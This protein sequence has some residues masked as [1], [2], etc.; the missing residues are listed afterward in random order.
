MQYNKGM[1]SNSR[2]E[3]ENRLH[4]RSSVEALTGL[5]N[6]Y[7]SVNLSQLSDD[8]KK[9]LTRLL[10]AEINKIKGNLPQY[11]KSH[12]GLWISSREEWLNRG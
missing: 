9:E 4:A 6:R 11:Y 3:Y 1:L 7:H 12:I 5:L 2:Q 8:Q 10:K